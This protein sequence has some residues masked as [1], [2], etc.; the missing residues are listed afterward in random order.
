M[1]LKQDLVVTEEG[2][3]VQFY[4]VEKLVLVSN[5]HLLLINKKERLH[6]LACED[7]GRSGVVELTVER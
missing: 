7:Y 1:H 6:F 4:D 5:D 2:P 3:L